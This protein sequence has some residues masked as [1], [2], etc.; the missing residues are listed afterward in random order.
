[1]PGFMLK[2]HHMTPVVLIILDGFGV[3]KPDL[4]NAIYRAKTPTF[5][6]LN[7]NAFMTSLQASG[8]A[9]GLPWGEA[10]NS[11][12]GHL[13]IG[14][15]QIIY[16][17]LPRISMAIRDDSFFTNWALEGAVKYVKTQGSRLHIIGLVSSGSVHAHLDHLHGL[18]ELAKRNGLSD[19]AL[20][21][22]T[23]GKD[24]YDHEALKFLPEVDERM[25]D[26]GVG[27]IASIIGRH[28][29][30]DR[31]QNW[32]RTE[33]AYRLLVRGE[34][35]AIQDIA[36]YINASYK[37]GIAD[38][39]IQPAVI[40]PRG[41]SPVVVQDKDAIIFFNFRE[42]SARQLTHVFC[43][44][45]FDHFER[46]ALPNLHF[47]TMTEYEKGL[48]ARAAFLP[49]QVNDT[50]GKAVAEKGFRQLRV[51]ETEKYAHITYFFDGVK[52]VVYPLEERILV[53]SQSIAHTDDRPEMRA[54]EITDVITAALDKGEFSFIAANFANADMVGHTGN[55]EAAIRAIEILDT[56]LNRILRAMT[57]HNYV[58]I[59]TAD[60]GNAEEKLDPNSGYRL[61]EHTTNPVP[62]WAIGAG[63]VGQ[64]IEG[65]L[66]EREPTGFLS[67]VA[68]TVLSLM[69]IPLP[70]EMTGHNLL[71]H[72][73]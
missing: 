57:K 68:P 54:P 53:P 7:K 72:R 13:T 36:G 56:S 35:I 33:K 58:L 30:M 37:Q 67:D 6:Y 61:S 11:E 17:Y 39:M 32:D 3:G 52:E 28:F 60:H 26:M 62:F 22:F 23:D 27:G 51:A 45:Q 4:G 14:A 63:I 70:K 34:G 49:P 29:A 64:N 66:Y 43:D 24:A 25:K 71:E 47:I 48:S 65:A 8:T 12:V 9:V 41:G 5:D 18:F 55:I 44:A 21:A 40:V 10:G 19:I 1:M 46:V 38:D 42:D 31:D 73:E 2:Y 59:V 50:L 69:E 15:G 20:H 16:Q